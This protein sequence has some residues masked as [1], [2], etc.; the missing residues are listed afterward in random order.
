MTILLMILTSGFWTCAPGGPLKAPTVA[1]PL[2]WL[3]LASA[4]LLSDNKLNLAAIALRV[5]LSFD[6]ALSILMTAP[7]GSLGGTGANL[8]IIKP[9]VYK[10]SSLLWLAHRSMSMRLVPHL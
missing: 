6:V 10:E 9:A 3:A 7:S 8:T 4:W 2:Y 5:A 1:I